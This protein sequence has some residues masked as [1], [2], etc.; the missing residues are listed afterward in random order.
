MAAVAGVTVL[1]VICA[2]ALAD[3]RARSDHR[4]VDYRDRR[5]MPRPP[6]AM[7]GVARDAPIPRDMRI[8][9]ALRPYQS[10]AG[11]R[12]E[13][14]AGRGG[15]SGSPGQTAHAEATAA[16]TGAEI[17]VASSGAGGEVSQG[18]GGI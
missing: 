10:P 2:Q 12:A 4:V 5:G 8:P 13:P 3:S 7:R 6:D 9:E 15:T 16:V 17:D 1:D 18:V 14:T 11:P